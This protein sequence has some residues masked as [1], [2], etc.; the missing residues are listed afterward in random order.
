MNTC[1]LVACGCGLLLTFSTRATEFNLNA[2]D[3]SMRNS[4]DISLLKDESVVV[5]GDYFVA[6]T[7]NKNTISSGRQLSWKKRDKDVAV[8][9]PVDLANQLGLKENVLQSFPVKN[10]CVDFSAN[11]DIVFTLD[12]PNQRLNISI[13]QVLMAWKSENWMPPSTWNNGI[14][15]LLFDYNLFA[16]HYSPAQGSSSRIIIPMVRRG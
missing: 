7:V 16:S 15:G 8:C 5:P 6:I 10:D 2:L 14:S 9:I 13:P 11:P 4:V 12:M 1:K 3:K